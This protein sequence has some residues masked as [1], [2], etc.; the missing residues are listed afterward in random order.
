MPPLSGSRYL[1][2]RGVEDTRG[3]RALTDREP[4]RYHPHSDNRVHRVVAGDTL[5]GLAGRYF[6][7]LPRACGLWWVI[8]DFQPRPIHDPTLML[9][10]GHTLYIPS[11][12]VL[13]DVIL[14]E[15][16]RRRHD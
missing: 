15:Q 2:C 5:W 7:P 16:R 4:Y 6:A 1:F 3:C 11:R 9:K 8:A 10:P 13:M 12:R 14:S